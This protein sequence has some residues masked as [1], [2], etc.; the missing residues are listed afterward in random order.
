ML[1]LFPGSV[2]LRIH[3]LVPLTE[4][5]VFYWET[6]KPA[7]VG[8]TS[9]AHLGKASRRPGSVISPQLPGVGS[10]L[11]CHCAVSDFILVVV[12]VASGFS[13]AGWGSKTDSECTVGYKF[14]CVNVHVKTKGHH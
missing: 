2:L 1:L 4:Q 10:Y 3:G 7:T 12:T 8:H 9:A 13:N 11:L 14:V 6:L 5:A